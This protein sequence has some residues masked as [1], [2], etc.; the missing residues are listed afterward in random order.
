MARRGG[1][2][3]PPLAPA[4]KRHGEVFERAALGAEAEFD[5]DESGDD[6]EAGA[7]QISGDDRAGRARRDERTEEPRAA[8]TAQER[9]EGV[10]ERDGE[11]AQ[12][13]GEGLADGEIGG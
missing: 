10:E 2:Q 1:P 12:L 11:R 5:L 13:Q 4:R 8:D 6:H 7:E 9:A 3:D